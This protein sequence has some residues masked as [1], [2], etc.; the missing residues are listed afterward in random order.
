MSG[1]AQ[2]NPPGFTYGGNLMLNQSHVVLAA[3]TVKFYRV[4][5][6]GARVPLAA[7]RGGEGGGGSTV[8]IISRALTAAEITAF[9]RFDVATALHLGFIDRFRSAHSAPVDRQG[10][11]RADRRRIA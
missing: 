8:D 11:R 1:I 4:T 2:S 7:G 3:D 9:H 6:T 5:P 10:Q